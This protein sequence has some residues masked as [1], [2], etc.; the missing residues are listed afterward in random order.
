MAFQNQ[1]ILMMLMLLK[2]LLWIRLIYMSSRSRSI[3]IIIQM[4][5]FPWKTNFL[6]EFQILSLDSLLLLYPHSFWQLTLHKES[7]TRAV[8]TFKCSFY[9]TLLI[10][11][12]HGLFI[13]TLTPC[14]FIVMVHWLQIFNIVQYILY[15]VCVYL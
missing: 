6:N 2:G 14:H 5:T 13:T 9:H 7:S 12:C 8:T 15:Y 10:I 3:F 11:S 4:N 1:R